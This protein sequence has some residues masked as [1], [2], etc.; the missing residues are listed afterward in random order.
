[1]ENEYKDLDKK[2]EQTEDLIDLN[3]DENLS[4]N[5]KFNS[6][7]KRVFNKRDIFLFPNILCYFRILVAIVYLIIYLWPYDFV[8]G[9]LLD[10]SNFLFNSTLCGLLLLVCGYTDFVDG[11]IA[12]K[13]NMQS[14]LGK[15]FDPLA[16]KLLQL[17]IGIGFAIKVAYFHE[18][19]DAFYIVYIMF[20]IFI[21]KEATLFFFNLYFI[22]KNTELKGPIFFGK[23]TT[24]IFYVDMGLLVVFYHYFLSL[25][26]YWIIT[27]MVSVPLILFSITYIT[28]FFEFAS[29]KKKIKLKKEIEQ[30]NK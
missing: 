22:S 30:K 14:H 9:Q 10:D 1:M 21:I 23:A 5:K 16:D 26:L 4:F 11:F 12:R 25:D 20:A 27:L 2:V 7:A 6:Y 19:W 24:F 28:Y 29:L 18:G 15:I 17:A 3:L 8:S 13:F